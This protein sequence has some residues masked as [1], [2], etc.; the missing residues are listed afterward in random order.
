MSK[1]FKTY[2]LYDHVY[3]C[4]ILLIIGGDKIEAQKYFYRRLELEVGDEELFCDESVGSTFSHK[5]K[6]G[7]MIWLKEPPSNPGTTSI[8]IHECFHAMNIVLQYSGV[9]P[10]NYENDEHYAYWLAWL[11]RTVLEKTRSLKE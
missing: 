3:Q 1:K 2:D 11:V 5:K 7:V 8:L 10:C 4:P 6:K 9:Q